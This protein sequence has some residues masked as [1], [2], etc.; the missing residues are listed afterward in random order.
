MIEKTYINLL[1]QLSNIEIIEKIISIQ[2]YPNE[3]KNIV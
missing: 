3:I 2:T 1:N